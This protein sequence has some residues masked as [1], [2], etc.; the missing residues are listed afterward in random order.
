MAFATLAACSLATCPTIAVVL[1]V[2]GVNPLDL[3]NVLMV[4]KSSG[5]AVM[6]FRARMRCTFAVEKPSCSASP[7]MV[8]FSA[9]FYSS[10]S[11]RQAESSEFKAVSH[12]NSVGWV[13]L[14]WI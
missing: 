13:S 9:S 7:W 10:R 11:A 2:L 12:C 6:T 4:A 5:D 1:V 3:R 14:H 8:R